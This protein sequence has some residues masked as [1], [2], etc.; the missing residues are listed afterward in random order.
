MNKSD[1]HTLFAA[2]ATVMLFSCRQT[3]KQDATRFTDTEVVHRLQDE[4]TQVIIYDVFTP[5]VASRIY[6][7]SSLA[8]YEAIRW[9]DSSSWSLAE[10]MHGFGPMPRPEAGRKYDFGL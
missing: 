2:I 10:R 3:P 9:A 8:G 1:Y 7:Y 5:P 4:L 6:A